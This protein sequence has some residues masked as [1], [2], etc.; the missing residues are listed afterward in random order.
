MSDKRYYLL[1][2]RKGIRKENEGNALALTVLLGTVT[3]ASRRGEQAPAS[4]DRCAG[5][6]FHGLSACQQSQLEGMRYI[7]RI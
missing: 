3:W 5:D 4:H 6:G 1:G 2:L 7:K